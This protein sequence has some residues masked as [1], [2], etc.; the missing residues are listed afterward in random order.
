M[1]DD[2]VLYDAAEE[3]ETRPFPK[4]FLFTGGFDSGKQGKEWPGSFE[5]DQKKGYFWHAAKSVPHPEQKNLA[6]IQIGLRGERRI[7]ETLRVSFRH[8]LVGTDRFDLHLPPSKTIHQ[9]ISKEDW[10]WTDLDLNRLK[11]FCPGDT[12]KE[13]QFRLPAACTL[14]IDDLLLYEPGSTTK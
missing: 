13:I 2:I 12:V 4:R 8:R 6:W 7:G 10:G 9:I 11:Q 3:K 1:I 14:W 5:I